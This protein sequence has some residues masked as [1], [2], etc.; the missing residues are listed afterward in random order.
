MSANHAEGSLRPDI[1]AGNIIPINRIFRPQGFDDLIDQSDG[2]LHITLGQ[3]DAATAVSLGLPCI[4]IGNQRGGFANPDQED[5][6]NTSPIHSEIKKIIEDHGIERVL[7]ICPPDSLKLGP[8]LAGNDMLTFADALKYQVIDLSV[9]SYECPPSKRKTVL[10]QHLDEWIRTAGRDRV[11]ADLNSHLAKQAKAY[12]GIRMLSLN[13]LL[14]APLRP[15]PKMLGDWLSHRSLILLYGPRGLGKTQFSLEVAVAVA[16]GGQFIGWQAPKAE[17]VLYIDGEM[18]G[19]IMRQRLS[20][21]TSSNGK[22]TAETLAIITPDISP[23]V[24]DL[25]SDEGRQD[26]TTVAE[27]HQ[28]KLVVLDNISSLCR[29]GSYSENDAESWADI[30]A[31]AIQ[32]RSKGITV[33]FVHHAGKSGEQRGTSKREDVMDVCIA[34]KPPGQKVSDHDGAAFEVHFTKSRDAH[35]EAVRPQHIALS[36]SEDGIRSWY[37]IEAVDPRIAEAK[38]LHAEGMSLRDIAD[39]MEIGKSTVDRLLKK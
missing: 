4:S 5:L 7:V 37:V 15:R 27:R 29:S 11:I 22:K 25:A 33:L 13:D 1:K 24:P 30:Q 10:D 36:T 34:L 12:A 3:K 26:I 6:T 19:S 17:N 20:E 31:W 39:T 2:T 38:R 21:I 28:A 14:R 35:G 18:N 9:A 8:R 23:V 16:T 32:M